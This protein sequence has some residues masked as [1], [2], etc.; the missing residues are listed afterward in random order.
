MEDKTFA[1]GGGL[2][3]STPR[4]ARYKRPGAALVAT[5]YA[6]K[7]GGYERIKGIERFDGRPAPSATD[8]TGEK[9]QRRNAI[10]E[11][12]GTGDL[13]GT[14]RYR[15]RTYSFRA[16]DENVIGMYRSSPSGWERVV[17]GNEMF[18]RG[19]SGT[20]PRRTQPL[21]GETSSAIADVIAADLISGSLDDG[22]AA[23]RLVMKDPRRPYS[24]P[25]GAIDQWQNGET[26]GLE[27][28]PGGGLLNTG[29]TVGANG[30]FVGYRHSPAPSFGNL[31]TRNPFASRP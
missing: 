27:A 8:D 19:C 20:I 25:A 12:P 11:V 17:F 13:L 29:L 30:G 6:S 21:V 22:D 2:D 9:T 26:V 4:A 5:N 18:L 24:S 14:F 10:A 23:V 7:E 28:S 16:V 31:L 1:L 3:L 15:G